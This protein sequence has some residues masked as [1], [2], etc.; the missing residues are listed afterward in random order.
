MGMVATLAFGGTV[1]QLNSAPGGADTLLWHTLGASGTSVPS[2]TLVTTTDG[3]TVTV[4]VSG[5][6]TGDI[7][8]EPGSWPGNFPNGDY[9]LYDGGPSGS[10]SGP[11][12]LTFANPVSFVGFQIQA[13]GEGAF[14]SQITAYNGSNSLGAFTVSGSTGFNM[15]GTFPGHP[16]HCGGD[17]QHPD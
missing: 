12:T 1:S 6:G 14:T 2:G 4:G 7:L 3:N 17:Y 9:V 5:T 15:A 11:V 16:G 10:G 13:V 8:E